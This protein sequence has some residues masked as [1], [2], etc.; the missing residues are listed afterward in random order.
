LEAEDGT[1]TGRKVQRGAA[2]GQW[3]VRLGRGQYVEN[4]FQT[5]CICS[6]T[7][8]SVIYTNDGS[9]D[10]NTVRLDG[11]TVGIFETTAISGGG[12]L[13]NVPRSSGRIGNSMELE[14][15][16]HRLRIVATRTDRY[17][18]EIDRTLLTL[19]CRGNS[20]CLDP[21]SKTPP[22]PP[23][24]HTTTKLPN[25]EPKDDIYRNNQIPHSAA[26]GQFT[27]GWELI[28]ALLTHYNIY[29]LIV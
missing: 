18:V 11:R 10:I 22:S 1:Y 28:L 9:S 2:S 4:T 29:C 20:S 27:V 15:G 17:R 21:T 19:N 5:R 7:V 26:S 12:S 3:T 24:S 25:T 23:T 6:V 13:W 8:T 16:T 14:P